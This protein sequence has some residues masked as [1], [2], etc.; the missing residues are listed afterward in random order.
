MTDD[1]SL[2]TAVEKAVERDIGIESVQVKLLRLTP[3][4]DVERWLQSTALQI[5]SD[6]AG[7]HWTS[8]EQ[9]ES[10]VEWPFLIVVVFWLATIFASF[11]VFAPPNSSVL[12][13]LFIASLSVAG[14]V[15]LMLEMDQP[16][17]GPIKISSAPLLNALRHLGQ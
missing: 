2:A 6:L 15:Y 11:G 13:A 4:N 17:S 3:E 9:I 12:V 8:F 10:T 16:Y 7:A 14:S 1:A 5:T